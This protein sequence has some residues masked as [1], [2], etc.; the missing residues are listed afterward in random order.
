MRF[1]PLLVHDT[2]WA[3]REMS[4][5][6]TVLAL[7]GGE[8]FY[9]FE[10]GDSDTVLKM[11][12]HNGK[13]VERLS[14]ERWLASTPR[15]GWVR[16]KVYCMHQKIEHMD[17]WAF[18]ELPVEVLE[19]ELLEAHK[20]VVYAQWGALA[21]RCVTGCAWF[22]LAALL[23]IVASGLYALGVGFAL[24]LMHNMQKDTRVPTSLMVVTALDWPTTL[25]KGM[26]ADN[27]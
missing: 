17:H 27:T 13:I 6:R 19:Q 11:W 12:A 8:Y 1:A 25:I 24:L 16:F 9:T 23:G 3:L 18:R 20:A 4:A 2:Q 15:D 22:G 26:L 14:C 7:Q 10:D 5:G 21:L